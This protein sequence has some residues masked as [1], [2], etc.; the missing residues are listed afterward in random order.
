MNISDITT[1][2]TSVSGRRTAFGENSFL[3]IGRKGQTVEGMI[4]TVS[5]RISINFNGVEVAVSGSAVQNAREG[6]IRRFRIMDVSK[7]S[8]V[9]KEVGNNQ[10]TEAARAM[11]GTSVN[12]SSYAFSD[13]LADGQMASE[14]NHQAGQNLSVLTGEDYQSMESE[15]GALQEYKESALDRAVERKKEKHQ[16]EME[17]QA[18]YHERCQETQEGL[19]KMQSLGFLEQKS[20]E[21]IAR[22]LERAD[23]P[24]SDA[25]IAR[26]S[27]ALQMAQAAGEMTDTTKVYLLENQLSPTIENLYHG[28][29]SGCTGY[30]IQ[31]A[32]EETWQALLPQVE[33]ILT[34]NGFAAEQHLDD[35]K[36]LFANDLPVTVENLQMLKTLDGIQH[37]DSDQVLEQ[38]LQAVSAGAAPEKA[39][40]DNSRFVIARERLLDFAGI[41]REDIIAAVQEAQP[42]VMD[43]INLSQLKQAKKNTA[44]APTEGQTERYTDI[45]TEGQAGQLVNIPMEGLSKLH[46]DPSLEGQEM[47][48]KD[49][50]LLTTR[51]QLEEIRLKMTL[52]SAVRMQEKGIDLE[53]TPLKELVEELRQMEQQYYAASLDRNGEIITDT[54]TSLMQETLEK[55]TDI[56]N[57]PAAILGT[58]IR[59]QELLTVNELHKAAVSATVQMQMYQADYEAV[60]TQVRTDLGD[61]IQK[62]FGNIPELL[63][64]LRL[65]DTQANERAV[66]ILGYNQMDITEENITLVKEQDARVNAVIDN[67]KPAVVLELIRRGENPLDTPLDQLNKT[68]RGIAEEQ[69]ITGEERYSRYLW[70]LEQDNAISPEERDGYIGIYRL[71]NQID[72]TDGAAVGAVLDANKSM[73]LGN[74]L[75]AVRTI[76]GR[77][78]DAKIDD[79]FGGLQDLQYVGRSISDQVASGFGS[80]DSQTDTGKGNDSSREYY[81]QMTSRLLKE[82]T[83]SAVQQISDGD[84]E[85]L[86]NTSLEMVKEKLEH[87]EGNPELERTMYEQYAERL[88]ETVEQSGQALRYLNQMEIPDTMVNIEAAEML[89][90]QGY[91]VQKEVYGRRSLLEEQEQ[92]ELEQEMAQLPEGLESEEA[93]AEH[94]QR[95][96]GFWEKILERAYAQKEITSLDLRNLKLL[97]QGLQLQK[98]LVSRHSYDIPIVTG[99]TVTSLNVTLIQG[100]EESGRVQISMSSPQ[101][102]VQEM[103]DSASNMDYGNISMEIK[104]TGREMK[105]LV[106]CDSRSGYDR[107]CAAKDSIIER[108]EE[109]GFQ[110]K[111]LSFGMDY[112]SRGEM[113][114]SEKGKQVPTSQLYQIAKLLVQ[115]TIQV[116]TEA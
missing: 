23:I 88:R 21:Q 43:Q 36:W 15:Q 48:Q 100:T 14:A 58:G 52:Q 13:Y 57:A 61:S 35:A 49:M 112:Q 29:Y 98:Q 50:A 1:Q 105:G 115:H 44:N 84:M 93:M 5:D 106:L 51:R 89:L 55:V 59:R 74:L 78:V 113:A 114:A 34:Q 3:S 12:T 85:R 96:E 22:A 75:T 30:G 104:V 2:N 103:E 27:S 91:D 69:D 110:V 4:S 63:E 72:K 25:C 108:L 111:N 54:Q 41:T 76:K 77:G 31:H 95:V 99:E 71:L 53:V 10:S 11:V 56:Q 16:W 26:I 47:S 64:Q 28:Q 102:E 107:L 38:I 109:K 17:R 116:V 18:A 82:I 65:E 81:S 67:M 46:T 24:V 20:P 68:L 7:D 6:E 83:P 73:T 70:Q 19:E 8:I 87:A 62:A 97:G 45:L 60:G 94:C 32:Q 39:S 79:A 66:R 92:Q 40:L 86:L 9:L 101:Q 42:D 90:E 33:G 37:M 80:G